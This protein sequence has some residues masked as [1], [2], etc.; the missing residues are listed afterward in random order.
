MLVR[1]RQPDFRAVLGTVWLEFATVY[2]GKDW[3]G[4]VL[5][6]HSDNLL[7]NYPSSIAFQ[8]GL[9]V[10]HSSD[11]RQDRHTQRAG[12]GNNELGDGGDP[13]INDLF[14]SHL[15]M[16]SE[17]TTPLLV[18]APKSL[19]T[20]RSVSESVVKERADIKR[21]REYRATVQGKSMQIL[22]GEFHRHTEISGD[23]GGDGALED[24]WRYAI[25]VAG[26]DW[27][28]NGDHDNGAGREYPWWLTQKTTD[29]FHLPGK[30]DPMFSYER[31][32]RYPEG[33]RNV[34]FPYRGVRT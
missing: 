3:T 19:L 7:Y 9:L 32:V 16:P 31:S 8:N 21:C 25:D 1:T 17:L 18:A 29:V 30:F 27:I 28:G 13:F 6:P 14:S 20:G 15:S 26:M 12:G 23:G 22:R 10:V 11:H 24:M 5:L 4:P 34:V 33:H 2:S